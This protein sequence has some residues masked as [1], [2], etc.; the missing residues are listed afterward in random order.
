MRITNTENSS[1]NEVILPAVILRIAAADLSDD[2][3]ATR[4]FFAQIFT[5]L[6]PAV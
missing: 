5:Y 4:K 2:I 1:T 3:D 6:Q